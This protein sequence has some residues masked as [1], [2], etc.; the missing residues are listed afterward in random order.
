M[1]LR[2]KASGSILKGFVFSQ[3]DFDKMIRFEKMIL[4]RSIIAGCLISLV[5]SVENCGLSIWFGSENENCSGSSNK[6]YSSLNFNG[7]CTMFENDPSFSTY[8]LEIDVENEQVKNFQVFY[9]KNCSQKNELFTVKTPVA[10]NRCVSLE[11]MGQVK[12][13]LTAG[14][15][16]FQCQN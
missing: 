2:K 13:S 7:N 12:D 8:R 10:L 6:N 5:F 1:D 11:L 4:V 15:L 16:I 9:Y 3:F 14:S